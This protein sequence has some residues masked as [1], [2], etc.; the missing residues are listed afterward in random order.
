MKEICFNEDQLTGLFKEKAEAFHRVYDN[1]DKTQ[2]FIIDQM[3][4]T[5]QLASCAY[6]AVV[7]QSR[8]VDAVD[9]ISE[10]G[11]TA[12]QFLIHFDI[13]KCHYKCNDEELC[14]KMNATSEWLK[15]RGWISLPEPKDETGAQHYKTAEGMLS[16]MKKY[17]SVYRQMLR[18]LKQNAEERKGVK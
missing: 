1:L 18:T 4:R 5:F 6:M 15:D 9:A 11:V 17:V 2:E 3:V 14:A 8:G 13:L 12:E 16:D 7:S 10:A